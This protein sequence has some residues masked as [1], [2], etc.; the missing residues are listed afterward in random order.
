MNE[1][2]KKENILKALFRSLILAVVL[3]IFPIISGAIIAINKMDT[4]PGYLLQGAFMMF[5]VL[6]P[7]IFMWIL[8]IK[9][10][11]IGLIK[12]EKG[13]GKALLF[14]LPLV[15]SKVG[16]LFFGINHDIHSVV[17]LVFFTL[18]I[19]VSEEIYFR[20]LI[21]RELSAC[22]TVRKTVI[23]SSVFFAAVHTAQAFAG[24]GV[25]MV[26][27]S[28]LNAFIF[29]VVAA[30]I[31]LKT[32]SI[33]PVIIWHTLFDFINWITLVRGTKEI[34][35]IVIQSIIMIA[36]ATY[37][38]INLPDKQESVLSQN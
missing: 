13:S 20:G 7:V 4:I 38:W 35:L 3:T 36:Y 14:F 18:T 21:L 2:K 32:K 34:V 15:L 9:P 33:L 19:G 30:E 26:V 24:S 11:Q 27:L 10:G 16:F 31:V 5:S 37:L 28:I 6:I 25:L 1:D 22:F 23:L 8:N 12:M 29:G 17:A